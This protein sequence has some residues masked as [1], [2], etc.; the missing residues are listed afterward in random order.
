M[1]KLTLLLINTLTL[2]ILSGCSLFTPFELK[3]ETITMEYGDTL[4][5][6]V[7][8][9][10][11]AGNYDEIAY[12]Y[13]EAYVEHSEFCQGNNL[14][15]ATFTNA[16]GENLTM[17]IVWIDTTA[18][19]ISD[20]EAIWYTIDTHFTN[21]SLLVEYSQ[22]T[23]TY[24][25]ELYSPYDNYNCFISKFSLDGELLYECE[26]SETLLIDEMLSTLEPN[27]L[28]ILNKWEGSIDYGAHE[29]QFE[30]TDYSG[31]TAT[32]TCTLHVVRD[33]SPE[34]RQAFLD[35]GG[36]E[37][38]LNAQIKS[39]L[40]EQKSK[41]EPWRT[42]EMAKLEKLVANCNKMFN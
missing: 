40:S 38:S 8:A 31:N 25:I 2:F 3:E 41:Y 17:N 4:S 21:K 39:I 26:P 29:L 19:T 42:D 9:Y 14:G 5:E 22:T 11:T 12:D 28:S 16:D 37:E 18:P 13:S 15:T 7:S 34:T 23:A 36:T 24:I 10:V 30:L 33:V 27:S 35:E 32:Y 1:K 6:D 20:T